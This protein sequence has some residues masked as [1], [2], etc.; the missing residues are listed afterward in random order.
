MIF[1]T[2]LSILSKYFNKYKRVAA[3]I[4][5]CGA[6]VGSFIFPIVIKTLEDAYGWRG[7][8]LMVGGMFAQSI[9]LA[10]LYKPV[11]T[12]VKCEK[13]YVEHQKGDFKGDASQML[14]DGANTKDCPQSG[15]IEKQEPQGIFD[16]S[17][18]HME[19]NTI[20]RPSKVLL[21]EEANVGQPKT[22]SNSLLK[23]VIFLFKS[24]SFL[25][26]C[27]HTMVLFFSILAVYTHYGSYILSIGFTRSD[28]ALLYMAVGIATTIGRLLL[29]IVAEVTKA[30]SLAIMM[31]SSMIAGGVTI[32][33][34]FTDNLII[35]YIY[36][37]SFGIL[38]SPWNTLCLPLTM[39]LVPQSQVATAF[40]VICLFTVPG[41]TL[42]APLA[43]SVKT[44]CI[45]G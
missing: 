23:K 18:N 4:S 43:G 41:Q 29:G 27:L 13:T 44:M 40:G 28:V 15:S 21:S 10:A 12:A 3:G 20:D 36:A 11:P 9:I 1:N 38:I 2:S 33:V 5:V 39:D 45:Q 26:L 14:A 17:G 6:G 30:N 34:P 31:A 32:V 37:V 8:I 19:N 25:C 16:S 35:L 24:L 22:D 7:A 42:G